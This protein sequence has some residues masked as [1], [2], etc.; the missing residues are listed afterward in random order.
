[1]TTVA[2]LPGDGIGPEVIA[3]SKR[4]LDLVA[5]LGVRLHVEEAPIGA[6]AYHLTGH[7]YPDS[8]RAL[9]DRADAVLFGAVG[10]S[11][12]DH[13]GALRPDAA[14]GAVRQQLD[15]TVGLRGVTVPPEMAEM[16][17]LRPELVSGVDLLVLREMGG[18][19]YV[20][21]PRGQRIASDG[22]FPGDDEG[23]DT[24]RYSAG[25]VRRVAI[26][27]FQMAQRRRKRVASADKAN[28]LETSR[29]WRRIVEE[30]ASDFPDVEC[31]HLYAD[32]LAM[33]LVTQ[34]R[35]F[36]IILTANLFGDIL[37]DVA[38]VLT[39]SIGLPGSA[40]LSPSGKALYEPGHGSA[41]DIAGRDR[42]NP[43]AAIRC[44]GLMMVHSFERPDLAAAIERAI[45]RVLGDGLRTA[46]IHRGAGK[47]V[48]TTE[49]GDAIVLALREELK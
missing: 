10:D 48:G 40:L 17:P 19:V 26:M 1:M 5:S 14:I 20:G 11:R 29:L 45:A 21:K 42:A 16:S 22:P 30:V 23:F 33:A 38:S 36:D 15:L 3:Q 44:V 34:P 32:N 27:A 8:T 18:D 39:G 2:V 41:F 4:V 25:E 37:S 9:V 28:V 31:T 43:I 6:T 49:M 47:L 7:P 24:M 12:L 46:D 35:Q 13:L